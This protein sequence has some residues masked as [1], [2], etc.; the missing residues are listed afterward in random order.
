METISNSNMT[1]FNLILFTGD[2]EVDSSLN[3]MKSKSFQLLSFLIQNEGSVIKNQFV[4]E[5]LSKL[6]R[7]SIS[8]LNAIVNE[9]M[10]YLSNMNKNNNEYPDNNYDILLFQILL[11]LSRFLG[12]EPIVTQFTGFVKK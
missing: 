8:S 4:I 5:N 2:K 12:R 10:E 3:S 11:F 1:E 7:L 6:V 9:K